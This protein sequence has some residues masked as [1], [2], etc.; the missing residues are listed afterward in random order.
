[1]SKKPLS[2]AALDRLLHRYRI[3]VDTGDSAIDALV[4]AAR[5][6]AARLKEDIDS[7]GFFGAIAAALGF[8]NLRPALLSGAALA[9]FTLVIG[10]SL[11]ATNAIPRLDSQS[12]ALDLDTVMG[13]NTLAT[14]T[15]LASEDDDAL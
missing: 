5:L 6:R 7:E 8:R 4:G 1:M 2:D 3:S 11:G 9:A 12:I 15:V 13:T 14:G 10:L